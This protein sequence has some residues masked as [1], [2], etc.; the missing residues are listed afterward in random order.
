MQITSMQPVSFGAIYK[1][2]KDGNSIYGESLTGSKAYDFYGTVNGDRLEV[3]F[4]PPFTIPD[5]ELY[6]AKA[7]INPNGNIDIKTYSLFGNQQKAST[8]FIKDVLD[9]AKKAFNLEGNYQQ[10]TKTIDNN[11]ETPEAFTRFT[12][13]G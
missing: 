11:S 10:I 7:Q 13:T 4:E 2:N 9:L 3:T 8:T 12:L 5:T 6:K 1:Y